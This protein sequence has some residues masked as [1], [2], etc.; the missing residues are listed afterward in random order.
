MSIRV[1][2][3]YSLITTSYNIGNPIPHQI[4][5]TSLTDSRDWIIRYCIVCSVA[6]LIWNLI[7]WT[8]L[9]FLYV[10]KSRYIYTYVTACVVTASVVVQHGVTPWWTATQSSIPYE[11]GYKLWLNMYESMI[12]AIQGFLWLWVCAF[13][14]IFFNL[15]I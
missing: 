8:Y 9:L 2:N 14:V 10:V 13:N 5:R 4:S 1:N 3:K 15:N 11:F 7:P 12:P 6:I